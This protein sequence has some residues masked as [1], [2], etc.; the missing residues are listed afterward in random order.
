MTNRMPSRHPTAIQKRRPLRNLLLSGLLFVCFYR[1]A[2]FMLLT[3]FPTSGA[4]SLPY[5]SRILMMAEPTIAPSETSAIFR[6]CSGVEIPNPTAHGILLCRRT[7]D[8]IDAR[9]V[10]I[11]LRVPV[12]PRLETM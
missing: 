1:K 8:T 5:F 6:A 2:S 9:S 12:T 10:V 3:Y 11:S 4:A 7:T